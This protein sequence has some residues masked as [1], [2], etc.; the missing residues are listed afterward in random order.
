MQLYLDLF[1]SDSLKALLD[2][3]ISYFDQNNITY[4]VQT[5]NNGVT[6][7]VTELFVIGR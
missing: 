4:R 7:I 2:I 3:I 1:F 6:T 5:E